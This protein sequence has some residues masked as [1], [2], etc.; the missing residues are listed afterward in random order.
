MCYTSHLWVLEPH[1]QP[2]HSHEPCLFVATCGRKQTQQ[3]SRHVV[4]WLPAVQLI[5]EDVKYVVFHALC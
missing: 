4:H 3:I 5:P 2:L 1:F